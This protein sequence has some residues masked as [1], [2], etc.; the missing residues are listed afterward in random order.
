MSKSLTHFGTDGI[1]KKST[2][3][4]PSLLYK[5]VRGLADYAEGTPKVLLAGDTRES[6]Q[7]ILS[8]LASAC[9]TCHIEYALADV[10]PTPAINYCFYKMGFDFA[11]D[12]TAS[13]N[14][15]TDN[16]IKIFERSKSTNGHGVKL[17]EAGKAGH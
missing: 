7:Q 15:Y 12:V 13:H 17:S 4:T 14:P 9:E 16:G 10:L 11:I 5:I 2:E 3:F 6:T 1:R 8:Y